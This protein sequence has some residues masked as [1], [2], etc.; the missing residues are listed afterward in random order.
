MQANSKQKLGIIAGEGVLPRTLSK[1]AMEQGIETV[2]VGMNLKSFI[3]LQGVYTHGKLIPGRQ[4]AKC[5]EY[6]HSLDVRDL[7]FIGKIHKLWALSQ[8]PFL[9]ELARS[10]LHR[11]MDLQDNTFHKVIKDLAE[12]AGF[13]IVSQA[14]FLQDL[15][16]KKG[17][18]TQRELTKEEMQDIEFGFDMAKKASALEVSQMVVIKNRSVMAFEAAEG[19][20]KTIERGCRL[21][22]KAGI[23]VK[24][25][26]KN[27]SDKFDLP[28]IGPRTIQTIAK[29]KGTVLAIEANST[30]I[31]EP[32][33][34]IKLANKL[35]VAL[36]AI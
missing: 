2:A 18:F 35:G 4:A 11:M 6:L 32:E 34:T 29:N 33:K 23:V 1:N 31:A 30:F 24:V 25:A 36:L 20:D 26:W 3:D 7:V 8:I 19:T 14:T 13:N 15:L 27:Q 21:A 10:Y 17:S 28:T 5:V 16:A 9:D 12:E 22:K